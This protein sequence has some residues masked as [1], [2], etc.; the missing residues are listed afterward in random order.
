MAALPTDD[1][2][3]CCT[4]I[5]DRYN[6]AYSHAKWTAWACM[7]GVVPAEVS[8]DDTSCWDF[9][10]NIPADSPTFGRGNTPDEALLDMKGKI[11]RIK[12]S[13]SIVFEFLPP[14]TRPL[15]NNS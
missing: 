2:L 4:I 9:W 13:E 10:E 3:W 8:G 1:E 6:G 5:L 14:T 12:L 7:P 11:S 15:P